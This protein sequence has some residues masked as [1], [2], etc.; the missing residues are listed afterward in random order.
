MRVFN[1]SV[2]DILSSYTGVATAN[3]YIKGILIEGTGNG[4]KHIGE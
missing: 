2:S 3:R 4:G 1:N